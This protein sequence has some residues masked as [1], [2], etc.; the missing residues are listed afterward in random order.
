MVV[1]VTAV[2]TDVTVLNDVVVA[3]TFTVET[4]GLTTVTAVTVT[5]TVETVFV[6]GAMFR[7]LH[8]VDIKEHAKATGAPA[9]EPAVGLVG[10]VV[11]VVVFGFLF[12]TW[13]SR[14]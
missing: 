13:T 10:V 8:A 4:V 7:Q 9:H 14:R 12:S 5:M 1:Y 2:V 6:A 11:V 3:T